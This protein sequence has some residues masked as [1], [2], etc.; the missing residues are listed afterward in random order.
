MQTSEPIPAKKKQTILEVILSVHVRIAVAKTACI[1]SDT[2]SRPLQCAG[3]ANRA[4]QRIEG[5]QIAI[6]KGVYFV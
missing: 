3:L 4:N 6:P 5:R 1:A 2:T